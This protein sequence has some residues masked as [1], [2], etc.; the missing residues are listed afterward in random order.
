MSTTLKKCLACLLCFVISVNSVMPAFAQSQTPPVAEPYQD[1]EFPFWV[2]ELRR[3]EI[4]SFGALPLVTMLSFWSYDIIR[5]IKHPGDERYY[6]WPLKKAGISVP[7]T[8]KEQTAIFFTSLGISIGI[9][10]TDICVRAI[11]RSVR[12]KKMIQE[13]IIHEPIRLEPLSN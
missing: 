10:L 7:L 6:P 3:F 12:E 13:N 8:K 9:A 5:S 2:K 4:L 11:I 1:N